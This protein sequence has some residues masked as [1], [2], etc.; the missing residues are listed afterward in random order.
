MTGPFLDAGPFISHS[1]FS[2][3]SVTRARLAVGWLLLVMQVDVAA[4]SGGGSEAEETTELFPAIP[5]RLNEWTRGTCGGS[6]WKDYTFTVDGSQPKANLHFE[7]QDITNELRVDA[8]DVHVVPHERPL[9]RHQLG[10]GSVY[11]VDNIYSR[12]LTYHEVETTTY[13][14]LVGCRSEPVPF[15]IRAT[16]TKA[17]LTPGAT[18]IGEVCP[19]N[20]LYHKVNL[21]AED[22]P[23]IAAQPES[24]YHVLLRLA[25]DSSN[26]T[27]IT[28]DNHA[29]LFLSPP[30]SH[31]S[32]EQTTTDGPT[33]LSFCDVRPGGL[34]YL[35]VV[36]SGT[37]CAQYTISATYKAGGSCEEVTMN[38]NSES[39]TGREVDLELRRF[40]RGHLEPLQTVDYRFI[41]PQS[42]H[43][44]LLVVLQDDSLGF[45]PTAMSLRMY[46]GSIPADRATELYSERS[47]NGVYSLGI[48]AWELTPGEYFFAVTAGQ[49]AVDYRLVAQ[50]ISAELYEEGGAVQG[51][52][53]PGSVMFHYYDTPTDA[54]GRNIRF[55]LRLHTGEAY[56]YTSVGHPPLKMIP[57][58]QHVTAEEQG[59]DSSRIPV[60]GAEAGA[61]TYI[62]IKA[63]DACT[64]YDISLEVMSPE[65][66]CH[67]LQHMC[68]DD[69]QVL[70]EEV[71]LE[72][73]HR[74]SC[75]AGESKRYMIT[76]TEEQAASN[77]EIQVED[78]SER[79][80]PS[81]LLLQHF[82]GSIPNDFQTQRFA[83]HAPNRLLSVTI[84]SWDL[85]PGRHFILVTCSP[86]APTEFSLYTHLSPAQLMPQQV[87]A[88]DLCPGNWFHYLISID[89][90]GEASRFATHA[91]DGQSG[92]VVAHVKF[93][94]WLHVGGL[95]LLTRQNVAPLKLV[96]PYHTTTALEQ[97][98]A[99]AAAG[100]GLL[101][102]EVWH[103]NAAAGQVY[104]GLRGFRACSSFELKAEVF[105]AS[106][107]TPEACS[108]A[109]APAAQ[110]A[111]SLDADLELAAEGVQPLRFGHAT[112][113]S[114]A[115]GSYQDFYFEVDAS[116][117]REYNLV[118]GLE[119][120][121]NSGNPT[122]LRLLLF[123][124]GI[125]K[126]RMTEHEASQAVGGE[127]SLPI[128]AW[129]M[130]AGRYFVSVKC[131]TE[132]SDFRLLPTLSKVELMGGERVSGTVCP[133]DLTLHRLDA[134]RLPSSRGKHLTWSLTMH[135]GDTDV[136]LAEEKPQLRLAPPYTHFRAEQSS[137]ATVETFHV[138]SC[139]IEQLTHYITLLSGDSCAEYDITATLHDSGSPCTPM[140]HQPR[141]Y[142]VN[143]G[144]TMEEFHYDSCAA[145][146]VRDY[147]LHIDEADSGKNLEISVQDLSPAGVAPDSL[148][149][150]LYEGAIPMD[151]RTEVFDEFSGGG[152]LFS[153]GVSS[154]DLEGPRNYFVSV[155][156][157]LSAAKF[158]ILPVLT[159][160]QLQQGNLPSG[161]K[162][163]GGKT[164]RKDVILFIPPPRCI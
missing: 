115:S 36:G 42:A 66:E 109:S 163:Q 148:G 140:L 118:L 7:V 57:P 11:G 137:T 134:G 31:V 29:P 129:D 54:E 119:D 157:R 51:E 61:R 41:V 75:V 17:L 38:S 152:G 2:S 116:E 32:A 142:V 25:V 3:R 126:D 130:H 49:Q 70:C 71:E 53:C 47:S 124:D 145:Y 50:D 1:H 105:A 164:A 113:S 24:T 159:E 117:D 132:S 98:S 13:F 147:L 121:T 5:L 114:C 28:A 88:A 69:C 139:D 160:S 74:D 45:N 110:R 65:E 21:T 156:C 37:H 103:C 39:Q 112:L 95:H 128:S 97:E 56:H 135:S 44:N 123:R 33:E 122:A 131:G 136:M 27:V 102:Y 19:G 46:K 120:L 4:Q 149:V 89:S 143:A 83:S 79:L 92:P 107:G 101:P 48:D 151:R 77:L 35:G 153:V 18:V 154:H 15:L 86:S 146:G 26:V 158:R 16:T 111:L 93:T 87:A 125:P 99:G 55:H 34:H 108:A 9:Y 10:S 60:C 82:E 138:S 14:I 141:E 81:A 162:R 150:Y 63:T 90:N 22:W 85:Q 62:A 8:L 20:W 144:L 96:P 104:L 30:L 52:V 155:K 127:Y 106:D 161:L 23:A 84:S 76:L 94:T 80:L 100:Q 6:G 91:A 12:S 73:R 59:G 133:G 68:V 72:H 43:Y 67:S 40:S 58:Y 78:R 64:M